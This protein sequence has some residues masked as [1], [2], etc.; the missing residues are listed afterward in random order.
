M[1]YRDCGQP[2]KVEVVFI[3]Y[4]P[5]RSASL[6]EQERA[7]ALAHAA[8]IGWRRSSKSFTSSKPDCPNSTS[9]TSMDHS[10]ACTDECDV[11]CAQHASYLDDFSGQIDHYPI[12]STPE[13]DD[14]VKLM[15]N[16]IIPQIYA[17]SRP[18]S[19]KSRK[20][21]SVDGGQSKFGSLHYSVSLPAE[22]LA[23]ISHYHD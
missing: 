9:A 20:A 23:P 10:K 19:S 12:D 22:A 5:N 11:A 17:V 3:T 7:R 18:L 21:R 16:V 13:I 2:E 6:S 14:L 4:D 8:R 1:T 15:R